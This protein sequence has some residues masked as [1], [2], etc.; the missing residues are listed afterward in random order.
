MHVIARQGLVCARYPWAFQVGAGDLRYLTKTGI[1]GRV[2]VA[3]HG[4]GTARW[5]KFS[6]PQRKTKNFRAFIMK[7]VAV[8]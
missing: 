7:D 4:G 2:K 3:V 5:V 8:L 6:A 1:G